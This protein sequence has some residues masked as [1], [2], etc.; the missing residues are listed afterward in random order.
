[1]PNK[2]VVCSDPE[3]DNYVGEEYNADF[4]NI[5]EYDW[6]E[7]K[8][9]IQK[10][11]EVILKHNSKNKDNLFNLITFANL[12]DLPA[13]S[14][15]NSF[16]ANTNKDHKLNSDEVL[17][18]GCSHT[19]G[20]GH[21]SQ[22]T[23]YTHILSN[24]LNKSAN[25]DAHRGRGNWLTEEKL[26]TYNLKNATVIIQFTDI[27]RIKLNGYDIPG[28]QYSKN[29]SAVFSNQVL[30]SI[31]LEQVKRIANL[32]RSNNAKFCFFQLSHYYPE[33][34]EVTSILTT[35]K[36]FIYIPDFNLDIADQ[37]I[38][39]QK[40]H[41]HGHHMGVISHTYWAELINDKFNELY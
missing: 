41:V 30:A 36:E 15:H 26:Q 40:K 1:M 7:L 5:I 16:Y 33:Q 2:L 38:T 8:Q 10:Y 27:F 29:Q 32:L 39:V 6:E 24:M 31:F 18:L 35:Y 23:V 17:Y 28:H 20:S 3:D 14:T 37:E 11:P 19:E 34:S 21:S 25:V 12:M 9:K 22:E 4:C 13:P